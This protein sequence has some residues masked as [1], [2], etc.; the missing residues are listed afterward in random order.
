MP[1][2]NNKKVRNITEIKK[3]ANSLILRKLLRS[4]VRNASIRYYTFKKKNEKREEMTWLNTL[5]NLK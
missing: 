5:T 2:G 3:A 4:T 1:Q